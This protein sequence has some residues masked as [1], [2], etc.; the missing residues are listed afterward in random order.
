MTHL[1]GERGGV[2]K[3]GEVEARETMPKRIGRPFADS[4]TALGGFPQLPRVRRLDSTAR[5]CQRREPG[6][7]VGLNRHKA[8]AGGFRLQC[9]DF[10]EVPVESDF[11]PVEP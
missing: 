9:G 1:E 6:F 3:L 2:L 8:A 7:Q 11:F 10:D 5:P 4:R